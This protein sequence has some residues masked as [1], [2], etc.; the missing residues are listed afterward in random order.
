LLIL[1][2]NVPGRC[3]ERLATFEMVDQR[4]ASGRGHADALAVVQSYA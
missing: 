2:R 1:V 3:A 4:E